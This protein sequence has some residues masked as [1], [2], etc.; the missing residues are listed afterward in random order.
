MPPV[1]LS[2][3][4]SGCRPKDPR[5][6][7][8]AP[9]MTSIS[10]LVAALFFLTPQDARGGRIADDVAR[11]AAATTNEQRFE[12]LTSMLRAR[13][14]TFTVEPFTIPKA[15]GREPRTEGRNVVVTLGEG[16][17]L[18]V[19]GAHYD[20]A[21][22]PD[23]SL[24]KGSVDNAAS[25]MLLIRAVESMR[26]EKLRARVRFVWFDMEELGLIGSA[27]Y[28]QQHAS[29]RV[30][31]MLNFDINGYGNTVIYGPS[32][33]AG[34]GELRKMLVQTCAA[35]SASCVAFPQIPPGDD[36]SFVKAG[37]PTLSIAILPAVETHQLWLM[38]NAG[39][40]SGLEKGTVPLIMRTIHTPDDTPDKI[41]EEQAS[42]MLRFV[43]A[44]VKNVSTR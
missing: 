3:L 33:H 27:Q 17:A 5:P 40:N 31:A 23:G 21:R 22:L 15:L 2:I 42:R 7:T 26:R 41:D 35:E 4:T 25:C 14:L 36:R 38:M 1:L 19:A 37:V 32:E 34:N 8:I 24:S 18:I 39:P 10:L 29:E 12:T 16:D 30:A 43:I 9:P 11:M 6:S 13:N 28:L 20:A 44:L